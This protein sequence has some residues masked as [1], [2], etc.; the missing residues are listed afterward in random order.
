MRDTTACQLIT[1]PFSGKICAHLAACSE[2]EIWAVSRRNN[3]I[4]SASLQRPKTTRTEKARHQ[5]AGCKLM[6]RK[7]CYEFSFLG[8]LAARRFPP[9]PSSRPAPSLVP[10]RSSRLAP[11]QIYLRDFTK[12]RAN[13]RP[14][15]LGWPGS[16]IE[17]QQRE[18]WRPQQPTGAIGSALKL[19]PA[20]SLGP[21]PVLATLRPASVSA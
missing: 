3:P 16:Q 1:H 12:P 21:A 13:E 7:L 6:H 9:P 5:Y 19:G 10:S 4:T 14:L 18:I 2:T 17:S 20:L 15:P 8:K 11:G